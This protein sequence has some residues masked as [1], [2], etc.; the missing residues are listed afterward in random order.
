MNSWKKGDI[1][2][3]KDYG[4]YVTFIEYSKEYED[5]FI[6]TDKDGSTY[7]DWLVCKFEKVEVTNEK[8]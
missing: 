8:N 7:T 4:Y 2:K 5:C 3:S 1:L 6:G